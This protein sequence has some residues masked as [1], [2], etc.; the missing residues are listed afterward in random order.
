MDVPFTDRRMACAV[1]YPPYETE[2]ALPGNI[3]LED[4]RRG[5]RPDSCSSRVR[6]LLPLIPRFHAQRGF[7]LAMMIR[8]E[9][10]ADNNHPDLELP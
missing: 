4:S 6:L 9:D 8:R 3:N 1:A 5:N 2:T 10:I 7:Q